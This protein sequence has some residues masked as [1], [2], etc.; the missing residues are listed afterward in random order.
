MREGREM[1][2]SIGFQGRVID[3]IDSQSLQRRAEQGQ[4]DGRDHP[5]HWSAPIIKRL[6]RVLTY[7]LENPLL[8]AALIVILLFTPIF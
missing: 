3:L 8:A 1:K 2:S 7:P 6:I 5:R 4:L